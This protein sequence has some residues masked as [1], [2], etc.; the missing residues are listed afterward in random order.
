MVANAPTRPPTRS[1]YGRRPPRGPRLVPLSRADQQRV[2]QLN[3][4]ADHLR[5]TGQPAMAEHV[6]YVLTPEGTAFVNRVRKENF[7]RALDEGDVP[8]NFP[9]QMDWTLREDI[10]R[11]AKAAGANLAAEAEHAL[12]EF[13]AGRF[14]PARPMVRAY[15]TG[16]VKANLNIRV[17]SVLRKEADELGKELLAQDELAWAPR[18]SNVIKSWFADRLEENFRNPIRKRY[19]GRELWT[20]DQCAEVTGV[21]GA[22]WLAAVESGTVPEPVVPGEDPL[23]DPD[24]VQSKNE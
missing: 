23:W 9:I 24:E 17:E 15:G 1:R 18:A 5:S 21:T 7:Q 3:Q 2:E 4:V 22:E 13:L 19:R 20:A 6:A 8:P 10:K 11:K 14:T 16:L 12:K